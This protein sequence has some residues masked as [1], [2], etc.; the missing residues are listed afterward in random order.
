[1][2]GSGAHPLPRWQRMRHPRLITRGVI[3]AVVYSHRA[4]PS[5]ENSDEFQCATRQCLEP[6]SKSK[7]TIGDRHRLS[8]SGSDWLRRS[9]ELTP[10]LN[11]ARRRKSGTVSAQQ[12]LLCSDWAGL[13]WLLQEWAK[14]LR[15]RPDPL[16]DG[17]SSPSRRSYWY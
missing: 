13:A 16:L 8:G 12:E 2:A 7:Y 17:H 3:T 10:W 11:Q 9:S 4:L 15:L 6:W 1:M 14:H 5:T